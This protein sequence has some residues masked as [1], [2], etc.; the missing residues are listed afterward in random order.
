MQTITCDVCKKKVEDSFTGRTFF[1]FA[2]HSICEVCKDSLEFQMRTTMRS[3]D[4]F[5]YEWY[6]KL[7]DDS[8]KKAIQKGKV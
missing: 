7:I 5:N 4:P 3:K 6:G 2:D 1:Y 8:I